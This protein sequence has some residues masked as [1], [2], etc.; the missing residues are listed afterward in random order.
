MSLGYF[1]EFRV[2]YWVQSTWPLTGN[3]VLRLNFLFTVFI[4]WKAGPWALFSVHLFTLHSYLVDMLL[5][6]VLGICLEQ[7][8][9]QF[10]KTF[11]L[12]WFFLFIFKNIIYCIWV[13]SPGVWATP[14]T[15]SHWRPERLWTSE[16]LPWN[17]SPLRD[18]PRSSE[19]LVM[20]RKTPNLTEG[21][22]CVL[23]LTAYP[24]IGWHHR[25]PSCHWSNVSTRSVPKSKI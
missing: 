13:L 24:I 19:S 15:G 18:L 25:A 20:K 6:R 12:I 1:N 5:P 11:V 21:S 4:K 23:K 8:T 22:H 10:K 14:S 9:E 16:G 2:L 17:F 3:L 7:K